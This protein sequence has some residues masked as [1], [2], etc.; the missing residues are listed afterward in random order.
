MWTIRGSLASEAGGCI[1]GMHWRWT[2]QT[3]TSE[4]DKVDGGEWNLS[5]DILSVVHVRIV[6]MD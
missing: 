4:V 1:G 5:R 3:E 6:V 2:E